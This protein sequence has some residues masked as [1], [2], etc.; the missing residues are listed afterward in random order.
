MSAEFGIDPLRILALQNLDGEQRKAAQQYIYTKSIN[1]DGSFNPRFFDALPEGQDRDGRAVGIS[2]SLL[3]AFYIKGGRVKVGEGAKKKLGQKAAQNKRKNVTKEQFLNTFGINPDGSFRSGT[4]ADG[5]I[6]ELVVQIS[7]LAANQEIRLN[8][9]E[10]RLA[11]ADVIA[12]LKDGTSEIMYSK[13]NPTKEQAKQM[14]QKYKEMSQTDLYA[15]YK[16]IRAQLDIQEIDKGSRV[17]DL[18]QIFDETAPS[19]YNKKLTQGQHL[20]NIKI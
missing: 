7:Q 1:E 18:G 13:K 11:A 2:K 15:E 5:A 9:V 4:D 6:R 12:K 20:D 14:G 19:K 17:K 16:R 3:E 10:N 8:A